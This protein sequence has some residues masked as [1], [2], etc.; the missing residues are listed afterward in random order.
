MISKVFKNGNVDVRKEKDYDENRFG[1]TNGIV[2]MISLLCD[3]AELDFILQQDALFG[4]GRYILYNSYTQKYYEVT[5]EMADEFDNLK[6]VKLI[7]YVPN[8]EYDIEYHE[9]LFAS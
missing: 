3:S 8:E 5:E 7:G 1:Q 6:R 2:G 4:M 9:S